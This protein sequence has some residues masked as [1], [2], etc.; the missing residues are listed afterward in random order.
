MAGNQYN[1]FTDS[2]VEAGVVDGNDNPVTQGA[3]TNFNQGLQDPGFDRF[4]PILSVDRFRKEYLFGIPLRAVLTGEVMS[5][6]TLKQFIRKGISDFESSVRIPV[7]PVYVEDRFDFERADDLSFGT[8]KVTRW[9]VLKVEHLRALWP[10]RNEVLNATGN[11]QEIDYPTSWVSLLGDTG[12][13]RIIPN[14]GTIVNSDV[15]FLASS[16]Y[17]TI[18]L[19]GLKSWPNMW[20]IIY[21]AGIDRDKVPDVVNDLIGIMAA[22]RVISMVAPMIFPLQSQ[23]VGLDGMSQSVTTFGPRWLELRM[24]ELMNERDRLVETLKGHYCT[25]I[26]FFAF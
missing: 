12:L 1:N 19:G 2:S 22:L 18:V 13:I 15:N 17:R 8:R 26:Q 21:W 5:D 16:A 25:D 24:Q 4:G 9:P 10:G 3:G 7:N 20:R 11:S 6:E 23:A 14:S